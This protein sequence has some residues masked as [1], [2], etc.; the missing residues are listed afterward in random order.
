M[1]FLKRI[2]NKTRDRITE[3]ENHKSIKALLVE[4]IVEERQPTV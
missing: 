1:R 2:E 4:T 3:V